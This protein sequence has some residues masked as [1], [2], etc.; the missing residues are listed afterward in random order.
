MMRV[1]ACARA[2]CDLIRIFSFLQRC[3][4]Y[5]DD[6]SRGACACVSILKWKFSFYGDF[7]ARRL[8]S[9]IHG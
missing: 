5:T 8:L 1:R 4:F 9:F 7:M 2:V 3:E 6:V